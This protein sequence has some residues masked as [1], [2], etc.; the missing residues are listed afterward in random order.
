MQQLIS[1]TLHS[2]ETMIKALEDELMKEKER[3]DQMTNQFRS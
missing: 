1:Q 2:K 3:R